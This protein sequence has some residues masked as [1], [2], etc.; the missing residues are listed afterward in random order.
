ME[1][2]LKRSYKLMFK[3]DVY[4]RNIED[5]QLHLHVI[6]K[7]LK[8]F[9]VTWYHTCH[10]LNIKIIKKLHLTVQKGV[11]CCMYPCDVISSVA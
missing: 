3:F 2:F 10:S 8:T 6:R 4:F 11:G 5:Y 7:S 1:L 9:L